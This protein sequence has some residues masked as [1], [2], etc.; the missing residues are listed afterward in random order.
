MQSR[1]GD[2]VRRNASGSSGSL[3]SRTPGSPVNSGALSRASLLPGPSLDPSAKNVPHAAE[4]A[5]LEPFG[6][7]RP[8]A[9]SELSVPRPQPS[10]SSASSSAASSSSSASP[11]SGSRK[12][13]SPAPLRSPAAP[14]K[15]KSTHGNWSNGAPKPPPVTSTADHDALVLAALHREVSRRAAESQQPLSQHPLAISNLLTDTAVNFALD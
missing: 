1:S 13:R 10:S 3:H 9:K 6:A 2:R 11:G 15:S 5:A 4:P 14:K 7:R 12:R 8:S